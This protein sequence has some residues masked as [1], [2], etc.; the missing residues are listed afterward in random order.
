MK[1]LFSKISKLFM[2]GIIH[3]TTIFMG[4]LKSTRARALK[5]ITG[6]TTDDEGTHDVI[7]ER[8]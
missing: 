4:S 8:Q 7:S 6:H 5:T 3:S 2:I 1:K